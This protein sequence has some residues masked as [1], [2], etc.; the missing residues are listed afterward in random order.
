MTEPTQP[1]G[2]PPKDPEVI[3]KKVLADPNTAEIA[4]NLGVSLEE[5]VN[6]VVH[7]VL[8]PNEDPS[9]Y[10]VEDEDL[11]AMGYEPPSGEE[12][13]RVVMNAANEA[14]AI[15]EAKGTTTG[16]VDAKKDPVSLQD[17]RV[18]RPGG[19]LESKDPQL[20]SDLDKQ[21]R[22]TRGDSK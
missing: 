10:I 2:Q 12:I 21:V 17:P 19:T 5:Y 3:R 1:K 13:G 8:H 4:K 7:Y 16:F 20:K 18:S 11:R 22:T 9:V 15:A 14:A 6:Q